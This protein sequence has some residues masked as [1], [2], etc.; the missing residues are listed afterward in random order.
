MTI[1][2]TEYRPTLSEIVGQNE[3]INEITSL[4]HFIFYSPQAGTGK[5]SLALAMAKDLG[6]PI[7]VFNASSKKTRGI[8]FVE[9]ELL[10]MSRTGNRN[11][12]FLRKSND[13]HGKSM[14]H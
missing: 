5:T 11:Q 9:E 8:D 12:F 1:W 3:V 14:F 13:F 10:P 6:W 7:H 4:Q 2:A